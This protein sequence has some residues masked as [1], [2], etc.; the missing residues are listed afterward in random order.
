MPHNSETKSWVLG[1]P[2][3]SKD[4]LRQAIK[5][6]QMELPGDDESGGKEGSIRRGF[7]DELREFR[8]ALKTLASP[9]E[10]AGMGQPET[11]TGP[12]SAELNWR[13]DYAKRVLKEKQAQQA[14]S[15]RPT[16]TFPTPSP[17]RTITSR[18][19]IT[20][21][22]VTS[23]TRVTSLEAEQKKRLQRTLGKFALVPPAKF[24]Q[25]NVSQAAKNLVQF[26]QTKI[27]DVKDT[28]K[29]W[30]DRARKTWDD[31]DMLQE[32]I[33]AVGA[34]NRSQKA[35]KYYREASS[36]VKGELRGQARHPK[37]SRTSPSISPRASSFVGRRA[38]PG[39]EIDDVTP[40]AIGGAV[41]G[42]ALLQKGAKYEAGKGPK[43]KVLDKNRVPLDPAEKRLVFARKAVWHH[44]SG[45]K[46]PRDTTGKTVSAVWKSV[47]KEKPWYVTATHRA[48]NVTPTLKGTIK[49]YHDFIE[50]T[51]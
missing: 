41:A 27:R 18:S 26:R 3:K 37:P 2:K 50:G 40:F 38:K 5:K 42:G 1:K 46:D 8:S 35:Q 13:I 51:A 32:R 7:E 17:P 12:A 28:A 49:R 36:K 20:L 10:H 19:R 43:Y 39:I 23:R 9:T 14:L 11:F 22:H 45:V 31:P 44:G 16:M 47:V 48:Y 24:L 25:S 34:F 4:I 6:P 29:V 15:P 33:Q 30:M 21:P